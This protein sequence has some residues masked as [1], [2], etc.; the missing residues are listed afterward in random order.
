MHSAKHRL[1][2]ASDGTAHQLVSHHF[3]DQAYGKKIY[4]QAGLHADEIPGMLVALT[5][6]AKL[7]QLEKE[8]RLRGEVVLV[9]TANPIGL[10][11]FVLGYPIGRF[12]LA[13]GR[14]FN[15]GFP[16]LAGK[17][18]EAVE[19]E[20][21]GDAKKNVATIRRVW[22]ELLLAQQPRQTFDDLQRTL[23]LLSLDADIIL[24]LHCS[25]EAALHLYTGES[26]W[27]QAEPLA[28]YLGA[29]A[30]LL[31]VDSGGQSFDEAHSF[32]WWQLQ[33]R[34]NER[35][36]IALGS[37]AITVEHRGQRDV[38]DELAEKDAA[39]IIDYL[40]WYGAIEAQVK[41]LPPL[42][43]PAT[44]LAGSE[45][46]YAPVTGILLHCVEPGARVSVGQQMFVIVDTTDCT[47]TAICSRT[48]GIFYMRRDV[49]YARQGDPLGRVSGEEVIRSGYLLSA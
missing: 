47:R 48:A 35:F 33:Q 49:R 17:I 32:T 7:Q 19:G 3:G 27:Q 9:S 43:C 20:L 6:Q 16:L 31:A 29:T 4:I 5:L 2:A 13:S 15:R 38:N 39:A 44:P 46:F 41:P 23:M 22:R 36:P 1:L 45:Q 26:L 40:T 24:D 42:A 8:G 18:A 28:R 10:G 37:T 21:G 12:D 30:S 14:N 25:R 34:F 11:Q